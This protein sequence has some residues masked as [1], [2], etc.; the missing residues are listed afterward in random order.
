MESSSER[1]PLPARIMFH[2]K[3]SVSKNVHENY[4]NERVKRL[5]SEGYVG[6]ENRT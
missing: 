6:E 3:N 4:A 2:I 5:K 1:R